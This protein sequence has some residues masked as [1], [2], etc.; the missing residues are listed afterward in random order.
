MIHIRIIN[1]LPSE[2]ISL[3]I[4]QLWILHEILVFA[5]VKTPLTFVI[6]GASLSASYDS[7][8]IGIYRNGRYF[9][10][11]SKPLNGLTI[12]VWYESRD[13]PGSSASV[14]KLH[15]SLNYPKPS[16]I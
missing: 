9:D 7:N 11:L 14:S 3:L 4:W 8:S 1:D 2:R 15:I 10:W 13:I 6:L 12:T 5:A 16:H